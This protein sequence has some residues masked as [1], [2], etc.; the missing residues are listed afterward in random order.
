MA[1]ALIELD[2]LVEAGEHQPLWQAL[3]PGRRRWQ[4]LAPVGQHA[5]GAGPAPL[6]LGETRAIRAT[7]LSS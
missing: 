2:M 5:E 6:Q 1:P 3:W 4:R 7:G